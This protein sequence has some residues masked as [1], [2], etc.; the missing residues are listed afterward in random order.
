MKKLI[1]ATC[2]AGAFMV[3][4]CTNN[5]TTTV[6]KGSLNEFDSLSYAVGVNLAQ[7]TTVQ[8]A[9][10]P[11]N[12]EVLVENLESTALGKNK[13]SH[14]DATATLQ[15]YFMTTRKGRAEA[16]EAER[17]AADSVA[18]ANGADADAVAAARAALPAAEAMFEND[19]ERDAISAALGND[20]GNS[21]KMAKIPAQLV[22]VS[23]AFDDAVAG[24]YKITEAEANALIQKFF[25]VTLPAQNA[26]ASA[27]WLA[28]IEKKSGVEK[29]ESGI[30]YKVEVAGDEAVMPT[31]DRDVVKVKYT[32][33]TRDGEVFD[34]SRFDDMEEAR[35]E[36]MKQN[37]ENG[38]LTEDM[39]II[40]FPLNRVIPGWTEGMKLVG[41]GGRIS[42]WLPSDLAYGERGAG[43]AI[44]ANEALYFDV[45]LIDVIPFEEP[46]ATQAE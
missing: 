44:G 11:L 20:L 39:E 22:W 30:L 7:M 28:D 2:V 43:A 33:K 40:E 6:T 8:L 3:T 35:L 18:L 23:A 32:G 21:I 14:E 38:E 15:E 26:E 10:L 34:S 4:S 13:T 25:M 27:E 12:Y 45:E 37:A 46:A 5:G 36:Y 42:L 31:D 9:D 19:K 29:T 24:E 16:V 1:V 41:K 17:D